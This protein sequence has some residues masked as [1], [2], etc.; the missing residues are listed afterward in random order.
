M[1][2]DIQ[3]EFVSRLADYARSIKVGDPFDPQSQ[4]GP[5][6]SGRQLDRVLGYVGIGQREGAKLTA[7]GNRLGGALADGYFIAPTV[8]DN[9]HNGMQ[10]ARE[11]IFG[12]VAS[13]IPFDTVEEALKLANDTEYGLGG[14][15]WTTNVNTM[16]RAIH[17]IRAGKMWVNGYGQSDPAV[18]FSGTKQS[19]YGMKGGSQHI[20]GFLY[21]KSVYINA[22]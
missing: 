8:F 20:E 1:Q 3:Q 2:R 9:V 15:L 7:G 14:G 5:L 11:E 13:I 12:P 22:D 4:L 6:V 18:G 19:G 10:I 21:E 16:M 17:G